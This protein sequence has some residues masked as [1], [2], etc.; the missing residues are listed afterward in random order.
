[1]AKAKNYKNM[2][3]LFERVKEG[4]ITTNNESSFKTFSNIQY[5]KKNE[6]IAPYLH[7]LDEMALSNSIRHYI[8]S[9]FIDNELLNK[10]LSKINLIKKD[11]GKPEINKED[12]KRKI[13]GIYDKFPKEIVSDIFNQYYSD[14]KKL[15]F[16]NRSE[17]NKQRFRFV[18]KANDP[19][20]KVITKES[21]I[22]SMIFSR[23][24]LQYLLSMLAIM[25]TENPEE[26][27]NYMN[28]LKQ[29]DTNKKNQKSDKNDKFD[30]DSNDDND[31]Q[32]NND[33]QNDKN[34]DLK[35]ESQSQNESDSNSSNAGKGDSDQK[36]N[37]NS[38]LENM[39]KKFL[40]KPDTF[41]NDMYETA[42]NQAKNTSEKIEKT[43]SKEELDELW[44][45]L[46][47]DVK[48]KAHQL[49][50]N[51]IS[52]IHNELMSIDI[53]G[54]V[55]KPRLKKIL[56]K[57]FSYFSGKE[58]SIYDEF[59]NNPNIDSILD[60][61]FLHPKLRKFALEDIQVK[62]TRK[63][64]KINVYVDVSG[65]MN[66]SSNI[67]DTK[68]SR[69]QFA[70]ALLIRLKKMDVINEFYTFNNKVKKNESELIN[71]IKISS[72]GGTS[73]QTVV[74]DIIRRDVNALVITDADDHFSI[75]SDKAFF[76]GVPGSNF[77]HC[78]TYARKE[79]VQNKQLIYFDGDNVYNINEDGFPI[80]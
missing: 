80:Y 65:S 49:D 70:Q 74:T 66:S 18:D 51:Y 7:K 28:N 53:N 37:T 60:F 26:Y 24:M 32:Q 40:E 79:Y 19:V 58:E 75:Y 25:K 78:Q 45:D 30:F 14:I 55:L 11:S 16:E 44:D 39:L 54:D 13:R 10:T 48:N 9:G 50:D 73:L 6:L 46:A 77:R 8:K 56:D 22:K 72:G 67:K 63:I 71:I 1:M 35:N 15:K 29:K 76:I 5:F 68:L 43:M 31:N 59:L 3:T 38:D 20:I 36:E 69:L 41:S 17:T 64:G 2:N 42:M 33:Q 21:N 27:H 23:N 62:D 52:Q 57:S 4:K 47:Y 34:E 61:E 12:L